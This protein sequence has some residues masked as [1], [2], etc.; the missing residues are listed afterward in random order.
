MTE[1]GS[2]KVKKRTGKLLSSFVV[3]TIVLSV[4]AASVASVSAQPPAPKPTEIVVSADPSSIPAVEGSTSTITA[5]VINWTGAGPGDLDVYFEIEE[6]DYGTSISPEWNRTDDAGKAYATLTAGAGVELGTVTVK[7]TGEGGIAVNTTQVTLSGAPEVARI[8]VSPPAAELI[9]G[10]TQPFTATA[11]DQYDVEMPDVEFAW[12]SSNETVGTVNGTGF[13]GASAL[14]STFVNATNASIVGSAS[15]T[16]TVYAPDLIVT[17]IMPNCDEIFGN[18][19]NEVCATIKNNGTAAAGAFN[20]SF[21]VDGFSEEVRIAAGLAAGAN[22]TRCVTDPTL[23]NAGDL[24]TITVT[25]DCD[26]E[27]I[28]LNEANNATVQAETVVNN[29]YKGKTYTGGENITTLQTH[30]LNGSVLYSV[31]DSYYLSGAT[32]WTTYTANWTASDL[33][34]PGAATIEKARLY[35]IYTWDKVQGMPD[36]VSMTFNDNLKTRDAFYTDRKGYGS[37]DYPCGMLAYEVTGDFNT[38]GNTAVLG[39]LNPVA[40]NPSIRGM[41]LVVIYADDSEPQRTIFVN[42]GF[43]LLYGGSGKCTT[44]EE[45]TAFAPFAG[46]IEDIGNKS[47]RLITVAPGAD[48]NEGELI[49]NGNVWTDVWNFA[50]ATQIGIDDRYVTSHLLAEDNEAAFQSSGDYMEASNAILVVEKVPPVKNFTID[51][52]TGYN[53]ISMPL[54]DTSVT[55]ASTLIDKI[56]AN[57]TEIFKWNTTTQGWE[58]YN[59]G[60]PPAAAFNIVGGEGYFVSMSGPETVVFRGK[61]WESPFA[62]SLVTGY[63]MIGIPVNDTSV[64]NASLLIAKIGANC[65]EIFKW[66]KTSQGWESYNPSMP[67]AAAFDI[68]C[69]EGYFVSMAGPADVAFE[70][71][72]CQD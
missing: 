59:P 3:L 48:P 22:T 71:E 14:G 28:E 41:L 47:A 57:C 38:S 70:G 1:K 58:S 13:F 18:E 21:A 45:A 30:T 53:M 63:N 4:L 36:N 60:M 24:V 8:E 27:V 72:P 10:G 46:A 64:T 44:P 7:V 43:D 65:T 67:P 12:T 61:G 52:V 6:P 49:F 23:R 2:E 16:V 50:G 25:A 51:F 33:P 11:Y 34:V 66:N 56:G 29:G 9:V 68:G 62:M 26:G 39:N 19:S 32:G 31:G 37:W 20:V 42:E 55:N 40:G 15:V 69:G 5:T 54:N 17:E 35:V